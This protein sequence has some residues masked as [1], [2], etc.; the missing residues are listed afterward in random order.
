MESMEGVKAR[1]ALREVRPPTPK[2]HSRTQFVEMDRER[3]TAELSVMTK[4]HHGTGGGG[5][6][7]CLSSPSMSKKRLQRSFSNNFFDL[8][9]EKSIFID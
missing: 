9:I 7:S 5:T 3:S 6:H 1:R 4:D 8:S 2:L